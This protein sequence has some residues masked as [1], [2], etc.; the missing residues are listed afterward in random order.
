MVKVAIDSDLFTG[1]VRFPEIIVTPSSA[2]TIE[3][4]KSSVNEVSSE[5]RI[6]IACVMGGVSK[7]G[8]DQQTD[9][10]LVSA[11]FARRVRRIDRGG[12]MGKLR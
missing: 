5:V 12:R 3:W 2:Q 6:A 11:R 10:Y 8:G 1:T 9:I 7:V 4:H